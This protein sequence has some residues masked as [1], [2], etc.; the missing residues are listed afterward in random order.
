MDAGIRDQV[1]YLGNGS[2]PRDLD[3]HVVVS[4]NDFNIVLALFEGLT[5]IDERTSQPVPAVAERWETSPD[6]LVW[7]FHLRPDA[8]WSN[9]DALTA[10][11]FCLRRSTASCRPGSPRSTPMCF[12]R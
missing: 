11:R 3:P 8:R 7:R 10:Q 4:F 2:E 1:L 12:T 5:N 9:G 6:G